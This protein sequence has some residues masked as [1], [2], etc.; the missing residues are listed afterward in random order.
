M[1]TWT[2]I[3]L[4]SLTLSLIGLW[5]FDWAQY[6]NREEMREALMID[7]RADMSSHKGNK[8][9]NTVGIFRD[10]L[11]GKVFGDSINDSLYRQFEKDGKPIEC[12]WPYSIDKVEQTSIGV[13][14]LIGSFLLWAISGLV[15]V[16]RFFEPK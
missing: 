3:I 2:K 14:A 10:K 8:S 4:L 11:T 15:L 1:K 16:F 13:F 6:R 12:K 5:V 9:Y 7:T